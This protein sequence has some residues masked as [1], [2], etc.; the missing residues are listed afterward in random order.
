MMVVLV[1][2]VPP[3]ND[4]RMLV[5]DSVAMALRQYATEIEKTNRAKLEDLPHD[6]VGLDGKGVFRATNGVVISEALGHD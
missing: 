4:D 5:S 3:H 2:D 1:L 6:P